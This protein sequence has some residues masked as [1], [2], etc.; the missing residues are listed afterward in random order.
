M[1]DTSTGHSRLTV[2][3][4]KYRKYLQI[5]PSAPYRSTTPSRIQIAPLAASRSPTTSTC[6]GWMYFLPCLIEYDTKDPARVGSCLPS[7]MGYWVMRWDATNVS[8][9]FAALSSASFDQTP[10]LPSTM[11]GSSPLSSSHGFRGSVWRAEFRGTRRVEF[12]FSSASRFA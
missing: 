3:P 7:G 12:M 8:T 5:W 9:F 4:I 2:N 10:S 1:R 11:R 6:P